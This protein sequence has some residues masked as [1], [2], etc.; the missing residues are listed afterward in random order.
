MGASIQI[1]GAQA[2]GVDETEL[3]L[4]IPSLD[5]NLE[6]EISVPEKNE[7]GLS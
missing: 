5:V 7:Q 6:Q 1:L 3:A 2:T 4:Q